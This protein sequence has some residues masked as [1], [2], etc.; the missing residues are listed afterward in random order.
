MAETKTH[1]ALVGRQFGTRAAAYLSSAV[2]AQGAD[3]ESLSTLVEEESGAESSAK[4][5]DL[6]KEKLKVGDK[7][8]ECKH[9]R[10]TFTHGEG[11][12][13]Y[14][15]TNESWV[16]DECPYPLKSIEKTTGARERTLESSVARFDKK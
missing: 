16:C 1:E 11:A 9:T 5:E 6:G 8:Y 7:E 15:G 13:K 14:T 12:A 4:V 10:S 2:H 3:L